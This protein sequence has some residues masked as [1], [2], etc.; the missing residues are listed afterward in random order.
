MGDPVVFDGANWGRNSCE[1]DWASWV[2]GWMEK[3]ARGA[4]VEDPR[5]GRGETEEVKSSLKWLW[6][7]F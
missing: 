4:G 5:G 3:K 6:Y 2:S 1:E 7:F